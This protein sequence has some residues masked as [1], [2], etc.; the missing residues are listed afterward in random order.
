[1]GPSCKQALSRGIHPSN[2]SGLRFERLY[3]MVGASM[4]AS[5]EV[6]S[7]PLSILCSPKTTPPSRPMS[8]ILTGTTWK[9]NHAGQS[10]FLTPTCSVSASKQTKNCPSC[11]AV[12]RAAGLSSCITE[13]K[14]TCVSNI[15]SILDGYSP[16][17]RSSFIHF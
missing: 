5:P 3:N 10:L 7:L 15:Y 12:A 6:R 16:H 13:N 17:P 4:S 1:M 11:A 9:R 14:T 8:C 2:D